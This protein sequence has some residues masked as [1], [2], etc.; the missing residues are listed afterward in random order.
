MEE[1]VAKITQCLSMISSCEQCDDLLRL[2]IKQRNNL[3]K[4]QNLWSKLYS[5][6]SELSD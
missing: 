5:A 6:K 2:V 3:P 4:T 1:N